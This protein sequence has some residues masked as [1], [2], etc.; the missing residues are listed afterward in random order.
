MKCM[1]CVPVA[2]L[3]V[4]AA[5][6]VPSAGSQTPAPK[7]AA[8]AAP[9]PEADAQKKNTA[10]YIALM[11]RDVRQEKAEIMGSMMALNAQDAAK[12]W[13]IYS[14]YDEQLNKLN[15]QRVAN[16]KLYVDNYNHLT[17]D[18]A[19]KMIQSAVAYQKARAELLGK[20]YEDVR[21]ALGG[22]TAARFALVEHQIL[23]I[24]DL[25]IVSSLPVAGQSM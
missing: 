1:N 24:I 4:F 13:P 23:S 11:R 6:A 12:F 7:L 14:A 18:Q 19:D 15:D 25:Q 10:A 16:I 22:V 8:K 17:D 20:T 21:Q 9:S 2:M 3:L 5:F